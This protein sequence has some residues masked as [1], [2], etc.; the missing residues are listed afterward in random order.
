M[1]ALVLACPNRLTI[2]KDLSAT[3]QSASPEVTA[4]A[5]LHTEE[6]TPPPPVHALLAKRS[7][8]IPSTLAIRSES[9]LAPAKVVRPSISR[10]AIPASSA[11][12]IMAWQANSN[13]L[14]GEAAR[15]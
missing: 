7:S 10:T 14:T 11:A 4:R 5:A 12:L 2:F 1:S 6:V 8:F 15:L 3:T 13:S 9:Q